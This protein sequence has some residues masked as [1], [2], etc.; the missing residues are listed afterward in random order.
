MEIDVSVILPSHNRFP[1]NLM[2]LYSLENQTYPHD[3]FEV[4]LIDDGSTDATSSI[5]STHTFPFPFHSLSAQGNIGRPAA[6][7]MGIKHAQGKWLIFLDAEIIVEPGFIASHVALHKA[8]DQLVAEGVLTMKGVY[9]QVSSAFSDKQK[10]QLAELLI[11]SPELLMRTKPYAEQGETVF[12]FTREEI[13]NGD[14]RKMMFKKPFEQAYENEILQR[15]GDRFEGFH[16]PWLSFYTGNVSLGKEAFLRH[17]LYEEYEGYG[18][19]DLEMG[20]RLFRQGYKFAHIRHPFTYHQEHPV[21]TLNEAEAEINFFKFQQ[22][23]R[24][25]EQLFLLLTFLPLP[26][27]VHRMNE[28]LGNYH[29]LLANEQPQQY[30]L[31]VPVLHRMLEAVGYLRRFELPITKLFDYTG[32]AYPGPIFDAFTQEIRWLE[33]SGK[34]PHLY[35]LMHYLLRV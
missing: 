33:R 8:Q 5:T 30:K 29:E 24:E 3:K 31:L 16:L 6:R 7:N 12:L 15:H 11:A 26:F 17:G 18:W 13:H 32:I 35:T 4:I 20:Y 28:A 25:I 22:K 14:F 27:A 10:H 21:S 34:Y 19:D 9:T 23:Y 1:L 2:T